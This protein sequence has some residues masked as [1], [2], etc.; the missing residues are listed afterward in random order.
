M[1]KLWSCILVVMMFM[2]T[3]SA[4][5]DDSPELSEWD[6]FPSD[7]II[8]PPSEMSTN[9]YE[10]EWDGFILPSIEPRYET[11]IVYSLSA[12]IV[13]NVT[14]PL[15]QGWR[16]RY[17]TSFSYEANQI[18]EAVDDYLYDEFGIDF[19][20]VAQPHW[21]EP[22]TNYE[23]TLFPH[24]I[25]TH[26]LTYGS[27]QQASL[28]IAFTVRSINPNG[29]AWLN[30][31]YALIKDLQNLNRNSK[32][33]QHEVGHAYGLGEC[34]LSSGCVMIPNGIATFFGQLCSSHWNTWN[35]NK[36]R[37]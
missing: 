15:D 8:P 16:S 27:G 14:T 3:I 2:T 28:M 10:E 5:A 34:S 33:V 19:V 30:Q 32:T 31:P 6:S 36:N 7:W 23:D 35:S 18:I 20:S 1:K 26:G 13:V 22:N 17:P 21:T 9:H 29:I 4:I 12:R 37:Y 25:N 11:F 24:V